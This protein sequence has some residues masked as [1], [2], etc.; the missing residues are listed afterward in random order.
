MTSVKS[1]RDKK[2]QSSVD[3]SSDNTPQ[4]NGISY[5]PA[6]PLNK[7]LEFCLYISYKTIIGLNLLAQTAI[8]TEN[9]YH[10]QTQNAVLTI[11]QYSRWG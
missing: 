11:Y 10:S 4:L 1:K 5:L 3:F 8:E 7:T 6:P 9:D 2:P